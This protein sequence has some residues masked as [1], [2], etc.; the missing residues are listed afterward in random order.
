[1]AP[2]DQG[3]GQGDGYRFRLD[4]ELA[5]NGRFRSQDLQ[6]NVPSSHDLRRDAV[7]RFAGWDR[8]GPV[9]LAKSDISPSL[10]LEIPA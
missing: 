8:R 2:G 7:W 5:A 6:T 9:L 10:P 3:S 1:M 4:R